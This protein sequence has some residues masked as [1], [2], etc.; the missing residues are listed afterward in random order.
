M[1]IRYLQ[2]LDAQVRDV[3]GNDVACDGWQFAAVD[4]L[5]FT[6]GQRAEARC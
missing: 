5:S 1:G 4:G 3:Q 6:T 2:V